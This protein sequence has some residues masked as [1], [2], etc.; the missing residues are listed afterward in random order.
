[1]EQET[2]RA[3]GGLIVDLYG[4]YFITLMQEYIDN[5]LVF[6]GFQTRKDQR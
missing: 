3:F 4:F 6:W 5:V 2:G 1:L